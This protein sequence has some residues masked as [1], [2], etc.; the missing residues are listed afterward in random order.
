MKSFGIGILGLG[1]IADFHVK[2]IQQIP[3]ARF[4][5]GFDIVPGK[6]DAFCE[7]Y[8]AKGY[9]DLDAFLSNPSIDVVTI[10]TPSGLHMDGALAAIQA[11]KH[12]LVEKPIEITIEKCDQIIEAAKANNVTLGGIFQSRFHR[13]AKILKKALDEG[14]FGKILLATAQVKWY[15]SQEYYDA[16]AWRGTWNLDGGGALMNQSIHAIDLLQWFVGSVEEVESKVATLAHERIEVEDTAVAILRL[17][18]GGFGVVESSTGI[19]PGFLKRIEICGTKGSAILEEED[20]IYW[21][22]DKETD[23]DATIRESFSSL[24]STGGGASNPTSIGIHG[25]VEQFKDFLGAIEK[26][27]EPLVSGEEARKSVEIIQAI[28]KSAKIGKSVRLPL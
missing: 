7:K 8:Q 24:S 5:A 3:N 25:H 15:R 19:F 28:Y 21:S 27:Q 14:R 2:A 23:E 1:T 17:K 18:D 22:F 9:S 26:N 20:I 11:K 12:V 6:A 4:V 16:V 13:G 10:T